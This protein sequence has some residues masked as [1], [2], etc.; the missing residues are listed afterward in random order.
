MTEG[1]ISKGKFLYCEQLI[2]KSKIG[3]HLAHHIKEIENISVA[4]NAKTYCHIEV[5]SGKIFINTIDKYTLCQYGPSSAAQSR[6]TDRHR[7]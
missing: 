7:A 6:A 3:T 2:S 4:K 5:E 1:I